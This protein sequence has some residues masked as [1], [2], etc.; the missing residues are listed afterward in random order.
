MNRELGSKAICNAV[1]LVKIAAER[2]IGHIGPPI[3]IEALCI[4]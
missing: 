2:R 3:F 4:R 1:M